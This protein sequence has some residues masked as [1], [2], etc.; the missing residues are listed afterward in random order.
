MGKKNQKVTPSKP[1]QGTQKA[2]ASGKV[3]KRG[4]S[5]QYML[6]SPLL[7]E[8]GIY[9]VYDDLSKCASLEKE[10]TNLH[11][12]FCV[13]EANQTIT[14]L[15]VKAFKES[16]KAFEAGISNIQM[17]NKKSKKKLP[18]KIQKQILF[19]QEI[20]KQLNNSLKLTTIIIEHQRIKRANIAKKSSKAYQK[21]KECLP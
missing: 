8:I 2:T 21:L 5:L 13:A 20:V 15:Q 1:L 7:R 19:W 10:H 16:I 6:S 18:A 17:F 9:I 3:L 14:A 12:Q 4:E 11:V